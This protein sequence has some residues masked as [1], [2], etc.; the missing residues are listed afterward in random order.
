MARH[1][2]GGR[3]VR[4]GHGV[5]PEAHRR[6]LLPRRL[7]ERGR[8]AQHQRRRR[9]PVAAGPRR[10]RHAHGVD[11]GGRRVARRQLRRRPGPRRGARGR[12]VVAARRVQ[13]VLV[14][15]PDGPVQR[16]RHPGGVRRRAARRRPRDLGVPR[17]DAAAHAAVH[18]EHRDRGVPRDAARR[19]GGVL[20]RERRA[21]RRHGAERVAVGDH[22]R[23]QHHR[24][25]VPDGDH[26]RQ[27]CL[28]R[29]N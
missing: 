3:E 8:P 21:R 27:Q 29:G 6:A 4:P 22:R 13:G 26:A 17:L 20:G 9:V 16:R 25:E 10:A 24:Q 7:R 11:G 23:R 5:Q 18:D 15:G 19:A 14:Q 28:P 1:V 2:C 12:A